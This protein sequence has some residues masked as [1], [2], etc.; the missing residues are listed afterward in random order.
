MRVPFQSTSLPYTFFSELSRFLW[1]GCVA[2]LCGGGSFLPIWGL[3]SLRILEF[4]ATSLNSFLKFLEEGRKG[5]RIVATMVVVVRTVAEARSQS[6]CR[7]L[8]NGGPQ[9]PH[10]PWGVPPLMSLSSVC[11]GGFKVELL[12]LLTHSLKVG[13]VSS[14]PHPDAI[15][16]HRECNQKVGLPMA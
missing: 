16:V 2:D 12:R 15:S 13:A 1:S 7:V 6:Q 14:I 9:G 4:L 8:R 5:G 10:L 11:I 3:L